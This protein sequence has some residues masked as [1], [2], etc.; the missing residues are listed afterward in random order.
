MKKILLVRLISILTEN[1]I[2]SKILTVILWL[3]TLTFISLDLM[4]VD[5][6]TSICTSSTVCHHLPQSVL[7]GTIPLL[8]SKKLEAI[9]MTSIIEYYNQVIVVDYF[10]HFMGNVLD[11]ILVSQR[12]KESNFHN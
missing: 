9:F 6:L 10:A 2:L 1:K 3:V 7:H 8:S 12:K 5:I 4:L 11:W